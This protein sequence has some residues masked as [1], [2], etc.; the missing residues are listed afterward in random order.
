MRFGGFGAQ[1]RSFRL[2][3]AIFILLGL[4]AATES[5]PAHAGP[6]STDTALSFN[7]TSQYASV[8]NQQIIPAAAATTF[9][10]EAWVF[11]TS[12]NTTYGTIVSQGS[13]SNQFYLKYS[14][15]NFIM[16][17]NGWTQEATCGVG[18]LNSWT[19]IAVVISSATQTCYINGTQS[20]SFSYGTSSSIG[21]N[22]FV[23]GQWS[24]VISQA[25]TYFGGEIDEVK[26][27]STDRSSNI[28]SDMQSYNPA[29]SGLSA[30]YDF[31]EGSGSALIN[32]VPGAS[33]S[34][35]LALIGSPI[36]VGVESSTVVNGDQVVTFPR[37]YLNS[38]GGWQIPS[39][40][41]TIRSLVVGG[42]GAGGSRAG[43]GGGAGGYIYDLSLAV[44][45]N[46]NQ[47][48][49]VGMGGYGAIASQGKNGGN[50]Q[51]GSLRIAIG[52]GG[53]GSANGT[54][55]ALR[56]GL[57]GG[58][59]GGA[60][61]DYSGVGSATYGNGTQNSTYGYGAGSTGGPANNSTGYWFG[62]GGG[63]ANLLNV[64]G[65]TATS[66]A[67]G[68]GGGGISDP[69][70]GTTTCYATG[71]GGGANAGYTFGNGGDCG[72]AANINNDSGTAGSAAPGYATPNTGAGGG[73]G[74]YSGSPDPIG[75]FGAS[76]VV[77]LR[78]PLNMS[79]TVSYSGGS[80]A[81]YRTTG[82]ITATT[83]LSGKVTFYDHGKA[84][85]TC[86][87]VATNGS[88]IATCTW[89][90]SLHGATT[91]TATAKPSNT[92]VPNGSANLNLT[93]GARSTKR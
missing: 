86:K 80:T 4:L 25:T 73:G 76:G 40:V 28:Q 39:S 75:G 7:G 64:S 6:T 16:Y 3:S 29:T 45:P 35:N 63:G 56:V 32:R 17:R 88:N 91:L 66:T 49:I 18:Q 30:Y 15:P 34:T 5:A 58:S 26:I 59:G 21:N 90:P 78:Y 11:I 53:G 23:I 36:Y 67:A 12:A 57:D 89:K 85:P 20:A 44:T 77:I 46:S 62:G 24:N 71:G 14:S 70:A 13:G 84:I 54:G 37:T 27:W 51:L 41:S 60:T 2:I 55:N 65:E 1:Y 93:V 10:V 92:Y 61:G 9:S 79:V 22:Y 31:N 38:S 50:S 19:H 47:T 74:G 33:A 43:G 69:I 8:A 82:T 72:G 68:K 87:N 81:T 48:I 83:T 52:G 42:G